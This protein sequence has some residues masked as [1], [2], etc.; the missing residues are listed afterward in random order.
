[1][2]VSTSHEREHQSHWN[3]R[4]NRPS[5]M[6]CLQPIS[7]KVSND[8][9]SL[10]PGFAR[11]LRFNAFGVTGSTSSGPRFIYRSMVQVSLGQFSSM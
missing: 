9:E 4:I 11:Y 5:S 8:A 10:M 1:M 3:I 2:G 6:Q 7:T